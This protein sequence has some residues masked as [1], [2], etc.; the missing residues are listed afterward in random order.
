MHL[1]VTGAN[2][3]IGQEVV[4]YA[5]SQNYQVSVLGTVPE[6]FS[7]CVTGYD[8][9]LDQPL[10]ERLPWKNIKAVIH[11][12]HQWHGDLKVGEQDPNLT[13]TTALLSCVRNHSIKRFVLASTISARPNAL[14][15]YGRLKAK[16]ESLL[17]GPEEVSARIGLVYGGALKSMWGTLVKLSGI[18]SILPMVDPNHAVQ[19]IHIRELAYGLCRLA[20]K[21]SLQSTRYTLAAHNSISFRDALKAIASAYHGSILKVVPLPGSVLLF[22]LQTLNKLPGIGHLFNP[23]RLLGLMGLPVLDSKDGLAELGLDI[24]DMRD[25]IELGQIS[26]RRRLDEAHTLLR[27]VSSGNLAPKL[28]HYRLYL[29]GLKINGLQAITPLPRTVRAAPALLRF[30]EP[31]NQTPLKR[32]LELATVIY[33]TSQQGSK[34]LYPYKKVGP[35]K[36]VATL[37][38]NGTVETVLWPCRKLLS[39]VFWP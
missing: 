30:C 6:D 12:A 37:I 29:T 24:A 31:M 38:L 3:Y 17:D 18:S 22:V 28:S 36:V 32:K 2:G 5:L 7:E 33:E 26:R 15:K 8:W 14:N 1:L 9:R 35:L 27:Y 23:E 21:D 19:P 13:G 39:K 25:G 4:R 11:L 20:T 16:L 10:P 34:K